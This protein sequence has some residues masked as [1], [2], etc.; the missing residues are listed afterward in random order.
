M[1]TLFALPRAAGA[2]DGVPPERLARL[3]RGINLSHWY[4]QSTDGQYRPER[5]DRWTTR[6]DADRIAALGFT[7]VRL[8]F[9]PTLL[10]TDP[11]APAKLDAGFLARLDEVVAMLLDAKLAVMVD[12]HPDTKFSDKLR[13]DAAFAKDFATFWGAL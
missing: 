5:L 1:I 3:A 13:E 6:E 10:W 2:D 9:D 8:P 12:M 11:A 7:Y 4:A